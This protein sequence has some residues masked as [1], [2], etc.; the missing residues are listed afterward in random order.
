MTQSVLHQNEASSLIRKL[1]D[2]V[3]AIYDKQSSQDLC[4]KNNDSLLRL[5]EEV[6]Q[7]LS[8]DI[9]CKTDDFLWILR[10]TKKLCQKIEDSNA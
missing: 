6:Q 8:G 5:S 10:V 9:L 7:P 1:L 2:V 3:R 4:A